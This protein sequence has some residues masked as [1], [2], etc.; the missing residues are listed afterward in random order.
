MK[1]KN[2]DFFGIIVNEEVK[3]SPFVESF[4]KL[5]KQKLSVQNTIKIIQLNKKLSDLEAVV[6]EAHSKLVSDKAE[7]KDMEDFFEITHEIE[8]EK[9]D[10]DELKL[11]DALALSPEEIIPLEELFTFS[12]K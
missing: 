10:L 6:I 1:I 9:I 7:Q 11:D 8:F 12:Q 4:Q 2:K 3:P 5:K